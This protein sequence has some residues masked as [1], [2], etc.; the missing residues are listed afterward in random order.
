MHLVLSV[1][2]GLSDVFAVVS[3]PVVIAA[4]ILGHQHE[5]CPASWAR[6]RMALRWVGRVGVLLLASCAAFLLSRSG[7]GLGLDRLDYGFLTGVPTLFVAAF[8]AY[9]ILALAVLAGSQRGT[10]MRAGVS[11]RQ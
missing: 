10:A 7:L 8:S 9:T 1:L 2:V 3:V 5:S 4:F 6:W 11:I